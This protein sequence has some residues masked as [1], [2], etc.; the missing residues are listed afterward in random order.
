MVCSVRINDSGEIY[1]RRQRGMSSA[2][3]WWGENIYR[4]SRTC[5][6]REREFRNCGLT[7]QLLIRRVVTVMVNG[8][9]VYNPLRPHR[10]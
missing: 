7:R 6:E 5:G 3:K 10:L 9:V 1:H 4:L 2:E 8:S